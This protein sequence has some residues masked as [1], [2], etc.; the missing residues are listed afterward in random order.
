MK[1]ALSRS[2]NLPEGRTQEEENAI[3]RRS[4]TP[5]H[6]CND[7]HFGFS[8]AILRALSFVRRLRRRILARLMVEIEVEER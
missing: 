1:T 3:S 5:L 4:I 7:E 6:R 2:C 8:L